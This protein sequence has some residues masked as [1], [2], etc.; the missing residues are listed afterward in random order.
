[1]LQVELSNNYIK[2]LEQ[3]NGYC[4]NFSVIIM[5]WN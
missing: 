4:N 2:L 1:M 3:K 5:D